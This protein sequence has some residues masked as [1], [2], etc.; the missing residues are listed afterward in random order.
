MK[1]KK[2]K[3][4]AISLLS[5]IKFVTAVE[6]SP[7]YVVSDSEEFELEK[8]ALKN[9]FFSAEWPEDALTI[10]AAMVALKIVW[11]L[12]LELSKKKAIFRGLILLYKE[13]MR[14]NERKIWSHTKL[15][16]KIINNVG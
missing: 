13:R 9:Y 14:P 4:V 15:G 5:G 2:D 16:K 6:H 3:W 10:A 1:D 12:E 7:W 8:D 11:P